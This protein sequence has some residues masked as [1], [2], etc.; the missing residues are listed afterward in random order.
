MID[1]SIQKY[2][3]ELKSLRIEH[4]VIEHPELKT[5][6]EVMGYLRL[7]LSL[8]VPT[9]IMKADDQ[10]IAFVRKGDTHIDMG[11]MRETLGAKR[12]RMA[13][14]EEFVRLTGVP[15]GAARVYTPGLPTFI[16][17]KVFEKEYL[18]GGTGS[19]TLTFKYRTAD[20]RKIPGNKI[21][22]VTDVLPEEKMISTKRVF[23]GI[24]PS[25]N[26]HLGNYIGAIKHWVAGQENGLNIF[27]IVDMHAIT[28]PQD[29]KQLHEKTLELAAILLAAGIDPEKSILFIQSLNPDHANLGWILNCHLSIG[30]MN[31]MTQ[32]KDKAKKQQVVSVGLFDY[33]ALMA[34]DIL[35]YDTTEVPI[36]ED[37]K[38]HV[39]LT[40]DVAERF[41]KQYGQTFVLPEPVI[42][43]VGGRVMDLKKPTQKMSKSDKDQSG[44]I[45]LLDSPEEIREKVASAV[46]DSGTEI[47]YDEEKK[48]GISN[49]ITMYSQLSGVS[50]DKAEKDFKSYS[51]VGFKKAVAE[52]VIESLGPLQ[53]RYRELRESG[54]LVKI[55]RRG[56]ERAREISGPKLTEVYERVGFVGSD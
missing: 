44:V 46:T 22:D 19:F 47:V 20:F 55:L 18:Y 35:L 52:K 32:Y 50:V 39:E 23:S 7:P 2:S 31:R 41:N 56:A 45:R 3:G 14:G 29:P 49:L 33:P 24:Q 27:C 43:K 10:F 9:L 48:P 1:S 12:L 5:P 25:G 11:K 4:E 26:L 8:S 53:N 28:V 21:I 17:K 36:G 34:A 6:P 38:Q 40:R 30:Q 37:Q 16:D 51:Y 13:N 42:P 15:V 54:E